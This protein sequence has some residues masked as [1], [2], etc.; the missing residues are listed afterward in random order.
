MYFF[1]R[2]A[3]VYHL[4]HELLVGLVAGLQYFWG[5]TFELCAIADESA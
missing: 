5:E 1:E 4:G 3:G 2:R